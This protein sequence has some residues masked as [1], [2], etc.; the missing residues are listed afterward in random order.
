MGLAAVCASVSSYIA[1][2]PSHLDGVHMSATFLGTLIGA[3]TLT[4][5]A[6]AFG[7]L[8]GVLK[9]APLNLPGEGV[10]GLQASQKWVVCGVLLRQ[11]W[12]QA[13]LHHPCISPLDPHSSYQTPHI[14]CRQEPHQSE[15]GRRKCSSRCGFHW[16]RRHRPSHRHCCPDCNHRVGGAAGR[17]HDCFNWRGGHAC[18]D[19]PAQQLQASSAVPGCLWLCLGVAWVRLPHTGGVAGQLC[20][21]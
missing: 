13:G 9:S 16:Q 5:S 3:I 10:E 20:A 12:R 6:V 21:S 2:D 19:H 15:P 11:S 4:G 17:T 8:H 18:G 1:A 14:P 7:K